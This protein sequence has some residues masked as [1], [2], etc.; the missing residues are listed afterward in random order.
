[1]HFGISIH[2]KT[3]HYSLFTLCK[4]NVSLYSWALFNIDNEVQ[5]LR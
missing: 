2:N 3:W 1:M 4:E 5:D